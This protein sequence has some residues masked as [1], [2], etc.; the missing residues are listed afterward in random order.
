MA[1]TTQTPSTRLHEPADRVKQLSP[2]LFVELDK[3]RRKLEA[4]GKDVIDLGVGD[5]DLPTPP[6][7]LERLKSAAD[8]PANHRYSFTEGIQELREAI[9]RW[10]DR[11][12]RVT[13]NPQTEILP[14]LGSKEGIALFPLAAANPGDAVLVPDPCYPP[15]RSGT[16][17]AGAEVVSMPLLEE[18]GFFPDVGA[19]SQRAARRAKVMFL[20]YPNNPTAAVATAEQFQDAIALA[21]EYGFAV[22]HDAAY[23]EVAFDGSQPI[24]FLQLPDAKAVGVEFHSLSKTYNM[25]GWRIGW[26]CGNAALVAALGKLKSHVDSGIFQPIQ[27]AGIAALEGDQEPL[28]QTVATYQQRRDLLVEGLANAGWKVA[29]PAASLY[30]WTRVPTKQSSMAF[31]TRLLEQAQVVITAGIGFGASGEGYIRMSL[32][33]PAE[34]LEE[35]VARLSKIL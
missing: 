20:N 32:T 8:D 1:E 4:A 17:L 14:L 6:H 18:N 5:P 16:I 33:V 15:Y 35:A 24:S 22:A 11:R 25:T 31:A 19:I 29:K 27:W 7:I 12:F 9:A 28:R 3:A 2:Y 10:Y 13:L 34:R 30:I 21:K 26:V 23:S